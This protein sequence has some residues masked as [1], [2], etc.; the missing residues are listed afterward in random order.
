MQSS[1]KC[2]QSI[3]E[4]GNWL[5]T[6]DLLLR[7]TSSTDRRQTLHPTVGEFFFLTVELFRHKHL[8]SNLVPKN[9]LL[10][11]VINN[12]SRLF[13]LVK[14]CESVFIFKRFID[15]VLKSEEEACQV[16]LLHSI[17]PSLIHLL[18]LPVCKEIA[19]CWIEEYG[20]K[21]PTSVTIA[22]TANNVCLECGVDQSGL[23]GTCVRKS[24]LLSIRCIAHLFDCLSRQNPSSGRPN[25]VIV[26]S[27]Y[28]YL[29]FSLLLHRS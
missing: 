9:G 2:L 8:V 4:N 21:L 28:L 18:G 25:H 6:L 15:V 19:K 10:K 14:M 17:I 23:I 3:S 20:D 5:S 29:M 24:I 11:C 1:H 26:H 27:S 13:S 22:H 7:E 12:L 16:T